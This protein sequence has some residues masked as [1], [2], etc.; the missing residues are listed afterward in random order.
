MLAQGSS[1][2]EVIP[3]KTNCSYF[4]NP[5]SKLPCRSLQKLQPKPYGCKNWHNTW[6]K[7]RGKN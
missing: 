3:Y 5:F 7:R 1:Y 2:Y 4:Q 6:R